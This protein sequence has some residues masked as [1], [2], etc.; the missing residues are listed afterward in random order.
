M[1]DQ[2][3]RALLELAYETATSF[4]LRI[5]EEQLA[6]H[7]L[8][9]DM[10]VGDTFASVL[11]KTRRCST[12]CFLNR[13]GRLYQLLELR[14]EDGADEMS[15]IIIRQE[16]RPVRAGHEVWAAISIVRY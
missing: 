1:H 4:L 16:H 9:F 15:S 11:I 12:Q 2:D 8:E 5:E 6:T 13:V 3:D 7:R 10:E 14:P